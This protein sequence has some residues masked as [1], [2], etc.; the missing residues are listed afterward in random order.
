MIITPV[1]IVLLSWFLQLIPKH[2]VPFCEYLCTCSDPLSSSLRED[3]MHSNGACVLN[4]MSCDGGPLVQTT[5]NL[6]VIKSQAHQT[7]WQ[8]EHIWNL[9]R[10][11]ARTRCRIVRKKSLPDHLCESWFAESTPRDVPKGEHRYLT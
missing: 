6:H 4:P 7:I 10:S 9:Q 3:L 1:W 11:L 5:R 8:A 2:C